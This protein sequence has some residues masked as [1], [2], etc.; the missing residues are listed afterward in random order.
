[1]IRAADKNKWSFLKKEFFAICYGLNTFI[2]I[3]LCLKVLVFDAIW[4]NKWRWGG[5]NV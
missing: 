4:E 3:W 2:L 1:M 5:N